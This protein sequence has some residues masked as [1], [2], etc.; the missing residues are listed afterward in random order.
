MVTWEDHR[1]VWRDKLSLW[2]VSSATLKR[3][4]G[5]G[6]STK[7]GR[8]VYSKSLPRVGSGS[9]SPC[10]SRGLETG[11][12]WRDGVSRVREVQ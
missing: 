3:T 11:V 9:H 5:R 1:A 8:E 6:K 10:A 2:K 12:R 4:P 7:G